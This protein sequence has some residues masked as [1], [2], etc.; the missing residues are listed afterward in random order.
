LHFRWNT[1]L[2]TCFRNKIWINFLKILTHTFYLLNLIELLFVFSL[3]IL[4]L[5][6]L[7]FFFIPLSCT[8]LR[9]ILKVRILIFGMSLKKIIDEGNLL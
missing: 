6:S 8:I 1:I 4:F 9:R 3:N 2:M 7:F 5:V